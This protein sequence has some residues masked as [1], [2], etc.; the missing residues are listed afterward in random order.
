MLKLFKYNWLRNSTIFY[1]TITVLLLLQV[2]LILS[3]NWWEVHDAVIFGLSIFAFV[4]GA[5]VLFTQICITYNNNLKSYTR[6]LLPVPPM[7]EIGAL[8]LLQMIYVVIMTAL[9]ALVNV[10]LLPKISFVDMDL[11][12]SFFDRPSLVIYTFVYELWAAA[13][14]LVFIMLAIAIAACFKTK[15]RVWIGIV[16]FIIMVGIT[17]YISELLFGADVNSGIE[18]TTEVEGFSMIMPEINVFDYV[19][20]IAFDVITMAL[21]LAMMVYLMNKKIEL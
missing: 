8:V 6:R 20:E 16:A 9:I 10:I 3:D 4:I 19:G 15:N 21:A 1:A 14:M 2:A 11:I 7:K 5:L 17:G 12:Y 18:L 13:S